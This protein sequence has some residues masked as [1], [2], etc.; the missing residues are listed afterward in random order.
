[1]SAS[2]PAGIANRKIG[3]VVA[4]CTSATMTGVDDNDVINQ[5]APISCIQVPMFEAIAA[6]QSMRNAGIFS[7]DQADVSVELA[8]SLKVFACVTGLSVRTQNN[9]NRAHPKM[10]PWARWR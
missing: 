7:G 4:V 1:M 3:K 10:G 6:I 8:V 2:A 5:P 9:R